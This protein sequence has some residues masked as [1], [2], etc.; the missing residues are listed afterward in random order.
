M[1]FSLAKTSKLSI[2]WMIPVEVAVVKLDTFFTDTMTPLSR[3]GRCVSVLEI[4]P[5]HTVVS[6]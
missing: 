5:A 1:Q 2:I 6:Q 3:L 4:N